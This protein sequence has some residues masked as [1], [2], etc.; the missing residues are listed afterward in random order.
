MTNWASQPRTVLE[1]VIRDRAMSYDETV[2]QFEAVAVE[3]DVDTTL[4][5]RHLRRLASG[6]R[7]GARPETQR[8]LEA[9][10][11][12]PLSALLQPWSPPTAIEVVTG[13]LETHPGAARGLSQKELLEMTVRRARQFQIAS[14]QYMAQEAIDQLRD[15]V[16]EVAESYPRKPLGHI[17]GDLVETQDTLFA[18]LDHRHRPVEAQQLY[19]LAG[20]VSGILAK[21]SHDMGDPHGA[22]THSRT[23]F[24]LADHA[25]HDGLR[26]W[27][28]SL[29]S[30]IAY[31]S[32]RPHDAIRY[33]A[34]AS[35]YAQRSGNTSAVFLA[36][37]EARA[38]ASLG[39][40]VE[41]R[42][43][44][45]RGEAAF[46]IARPDEVDAF[47]GICTFG[48][49]R[50]L[51]YAADALAQLPDAA[52]DAVGYAD[53]ALAAFS[54]TSAPDWSFSD[55]AGSRA[56]L[57]I[58]RISMG[59]IEGAVEAMEPVLELDPSRRIHGIITSA[60]RVHQAL[61]QAGQSSVATDLQVEIETF[62]RTSPAALRP[63]DVS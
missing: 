7:T 50:Q 13:D 1:S 49:S 62:T 26:A 55:Q 17:L 6:E 2:R 14:G 23:S 34:D 53:Q 36:A 45:G 28:K 43:A 11:G 29:Q 27:I 60:E 39:N 51:Y 54:D 61:G 3:L 40:S 31:W 9:V 10:F 63:S 47:G 25:D 48:R 52:D 19:M 18:L 12:Q 57:A 22:L 37:N 42:A 58:A 4:S 8:V 30:F 16:R 59:E 5:S 21:A 38:W 33:A 20:V 46:E 56:D 32:K 44:I 24:L 35:Q 41:A 15:D